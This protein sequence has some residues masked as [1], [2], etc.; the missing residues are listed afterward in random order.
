MFVLLALAVGTFLVLT[1]KF[2]V[3]TSTNCI[4]ALGQLYLTCHFWEGILRLAGCSFLLLWAMCAVCELQA[5][6]EAGNAGERI[7]SPLIP[8]P[9]WSRVIGF[10]FPPIIQPAPSLSGV[11]APTVSAAFQLVASF[12]LQR[13]TCVDGELLGWLLLLSCS[14][15]LPSL[16]FVLK[17]AFRSLIYTAGEG[18]WYC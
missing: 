13:I 4:V 8:P 1:H 10:S 17:A 2:P 14:Q 6:Q 3:A 11:F 15:Q 18:D 12:L 5:T 16:A 9:L 7:L